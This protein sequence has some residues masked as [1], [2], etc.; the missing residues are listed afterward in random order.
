M[1]GQ[2]VLSKY[3]LIAVNQVNA[4]YEHVERHMIP[5][6]TYTR[7]SVIAENLLSTL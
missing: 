2:G 4:V 7:E 6:D 5:C 3:I 1:A